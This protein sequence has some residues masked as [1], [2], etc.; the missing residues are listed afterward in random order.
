[1]PYLFVDSLS[2][3]ELLISFASFSRWFEPLVQ[4]AP[5]VKEKEKD[6]SGK[7]E[8]LF[9]MFTCSEECRKNVVY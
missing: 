4:T 3:I 8:Y 9:L 7:C 1:M 5:A 6:G 2:K